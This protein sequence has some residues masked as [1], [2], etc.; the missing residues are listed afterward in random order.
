MRLT[1]LNILALLF[2]LPLQTLSYVK[3]FSHLQHSLAHHDQEEAHG[4]SHDHSSGHEH[5]E[6]APSNDPV[7]H[8]HS[9]DE[10]LHSHA[11]DFWGI[12]S[13][14]IALQ[15]APHQDTSLI[16]H[17]YPHT[18]TFFVES[19]HSQYSARSLLRPPIRA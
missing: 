15:S 10:P 19:L 13:N 1:V 2:I 5:D 4:N 11:K 12:F 7:T 9:P 8:R 16:D 6:S 3:T 17:S 18:A 14:A